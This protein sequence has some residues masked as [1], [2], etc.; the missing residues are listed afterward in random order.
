MSR[1][2]KPGITRS[3][4]DTEKGL[5]LL[6]KPE[7]KGQVFFVTS[8]LRERKVF[9]LQKVLPSFVNIRSKNL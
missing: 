6:F 1:I 7:P 3:H 8:C 9:M 4:R 2:K 5:N